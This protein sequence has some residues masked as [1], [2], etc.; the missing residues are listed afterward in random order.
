MRYPDERTEETEKN[1]SSMTF[2]SDVN[3]EN[4]DEDDRVSTCRV[5]AT[6]CLDDVI[7]LVLEAHSTKE[8]KVYGKSFDRDNRASRV[9]AGELSENGIRIRGVSNDASQRGGPKSRA[10]S[11]GGGS[12]SSSIHPAH[13]YA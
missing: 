11:R 3:N 4:F 13:E 2:R 6:P 10:L 9:I 8:E 7:P 5:D 12:P 1:T